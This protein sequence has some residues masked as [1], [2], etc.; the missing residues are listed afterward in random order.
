MRINQPIDPIIRKRVRITGNSHFITKWFSMLSV[1]A[2][3]GGGVHISSGIVESMMFDDEHGDSLNTEH[4]T[5]SDEFVDVSMNSIQEINPNNISNTLVKNYSNFTKVG[6]KRVAIKLYDSQ[7][8][9]SKD[10]KVLLDKAYEQIAMKRLTSPE[11]NNAYET[12]QIIAKKDSQVAKKV[13]DNIIVWYFSQGEKLLSKNRVTNFDGR[14]NAY[15]MYQKLLEIAPNRRETNQ[16][17]VKITN[18]LLTEAQE[19]IVKQQYSTPKNYNAAATFK[20]ILTISPNNIK[21]KK[22]LKKIVRQYYKLALRKYNQR[23]YKSSMIWLER[24]LNV[25]DS[26]PDLNKLKQIVAK[27]IK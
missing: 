21:A 24:G 27:K 20:R 25:L 12:Y 4:V 8:T 17:L 5:I 14:N 11:G 26:D 7:N 15:G 13:L 1:I 16:L 18:Q 19:Q 23:N 6:L 9:T 3:I 10:L 22:G 2:I